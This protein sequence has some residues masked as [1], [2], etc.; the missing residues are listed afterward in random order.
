MSKASKRSADQFVSGA[1]RLPCLPL[2]LYAST[3]FTERRI[4]PK[5]RTSKRH[6]G[7]FR[8]LRTDLVFLE[9]LGLHHRQQRG[10]GAFRSRVVLV[11]LS[12]FQLILL[13]VLASLRRPAVTGS[14]LRLRCE[15]PRGAESTARFESPL[16]A[17]LPHAVHHASRIPD[18]LVTHLRRTVLNWHRR[19][20]LD[21]R[22]HWSSDGILDSDFDRRIHIDSSL[23]R[24][25]IE[26]REQ[27]RAVLDQLSNFGRHGHEHHVFLLVHVLHYLRRRRRWCDHDGVGRE[28]HLL[29]PGIPENTRDA[30]QV[31]LAHAADS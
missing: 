13:L 26:G 30:R 3:T 22:A 23:D 5:L 15:R 18:S 28:P 19:S 29:R 11:D 10:I 24:I 16:W 12:I 21:G 6:G 14:R 2:A 25:L 8:L 9:L 27:R 1:W 31:L 20:G 17:L 7:P 4:H